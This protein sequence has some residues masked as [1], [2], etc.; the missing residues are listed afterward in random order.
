[1]NLNELSHTDLAKL[2]DNLQGL[3]CGSADKGFRIDH[4]LNGTNMSSCSVFIKDHRI[5]D[6]I[7]IFQM[8]VYNELCARFS[9]PFDLEKLR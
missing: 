2:Y 9:K 5:N 7:F 1:M 4:N 3:H 8:E 6:L